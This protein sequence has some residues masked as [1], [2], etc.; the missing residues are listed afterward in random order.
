MLCLQKK[1]DHFTDDDTETRRLC[2]SISLQYINGMSKR[3]YY[4]FLSDSLGDVAYSL[5]GW[6]YMEAPDECEP[7]QHVDTSIFCFCNSDLCN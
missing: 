7:S 5:H 1:T 3:T 6:Y 2:L 4:V